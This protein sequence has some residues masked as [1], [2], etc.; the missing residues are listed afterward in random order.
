MSGLGRVCK[1][2]MY[3]R[4]SSI[5]LFR[6]AAS[7]LLCKHALVFSLDRRHRDVLFE[8][9]QLPGV[10]YQ[11]HSVGG[12]KLLPSGVRICRRITFTSCAVVL[13]CW[14]GDSVDKEAL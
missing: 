11:A 6:K 10:L 3:P 2:T 14:Y 7:E 9:D 4:H 5:R 12:S 8:H 13:C 1:L